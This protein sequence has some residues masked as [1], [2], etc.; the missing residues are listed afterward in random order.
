MAGL[1]TTPV[2][3][4]AGQ[5]L[6]SANWNAGVRDSLEAVAKPFR[7][8][9]NR[10]AVQ[11]IPSATSTDIIWQNE[12]YDDGNLWVVGAPTVFTIPANGA[13][14][15]RVTLNALFAIN[16]TGAR[17]LVIVKNAAT[18]ATF[19]GAGNASWY[20]GATVA[21]DVLMAVGDTVKA[22]VYQAS[23]VALNIDTIASVSFSIAQIAR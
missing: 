13:G 14:L 19:N 21:A 18:L 3:A 16:A 12:E 22:V 5:N 20:V 2:T 4:V 7:A 6:S 8:K 1:Y 9:V 11:S 15:Y 23:G 17:Q 10:S